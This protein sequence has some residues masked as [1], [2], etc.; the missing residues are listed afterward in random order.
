MQAKFINFLASGLVMVYGVIAVLGILFFF[1]TYTG[2]DLIMAG[3]IWLIGMI[4][5]LSLATV[6]QRRWRPSFS[7]T[8]G[9]VALLC[10]MNVM[11]ART[12]SE[13]VWQLFRL[14]YVVFISL[15]VL[16]MLSFK[17]KAGNSDQ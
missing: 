11:Y 1:N 5:L 15:A 12:P 2:L 17:S 8:L 3:M 14:E 4:F 13:E 6:F 7:L 16:M 9:A 10:A